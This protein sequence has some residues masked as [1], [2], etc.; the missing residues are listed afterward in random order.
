MLSFHNNTEIKAKYL[1]RLEAHRAADEIIQGTGF[2]NGK[3]CAV[4]CTLDNYSHEAYE[5][6]LGIPRILAKLE[7][8]IFE[9]LS[10]ENSKDFPI[11]FLSS[12]PVG[13]DLKNVC[14]KFFIWLLTDPTDGVIRFANTEQTKQAI[15]NVSDLLQKSLLEKVT[16]EEFIEARRAARKAAAAAYAA[17]AY[18]AD[19]AADAADAYAAD[20]RKNFY[21]KMADKICEILSNEK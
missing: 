7:D 1:A 13:V 4:G 21:K 3:G 20:A 16:S 2:K 11:N 8:R 14:K 5:T 18:A 15:Q 17:D 19:A 12:V 10:V 9:G 6:E